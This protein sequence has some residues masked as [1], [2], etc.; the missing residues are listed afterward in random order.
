[1]GL[2]F[3]GHKIRPFLGDPVSEPRMADPRAIVLFVAS[4]MRRRAKAHD[5]LPGMFTLRLI[6]RKLAW[7]PSP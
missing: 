1:M 7:R 5:P 3:G 4:S 2:P 6:L